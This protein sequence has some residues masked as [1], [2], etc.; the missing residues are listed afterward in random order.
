MK[1]EKEK[2]KIILHTCCAVCGAFLAEKLKENFEPAIFFYNPNIWPKEEYNKR[3]ESAQEL[4]RIYNLK[5][6]EGDHEHE[7]WLGAVKGFEKEPEDGKRCEICFKMR[8]SKAAELAKTE[9]IE[10][11]ATTLSISPY[12]N[13]KIVNEIG[14]SIRNSSGIKFLKL[15]DICDKKE[16]WQKTRQLSKEYNFYHQNYCGCE[17]SKK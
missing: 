17:F 2:S 14:E 5:F 13:E 1:S 11:F 8:L 7:K 15:E 6:I 3:K 10:Y 9:R 4:A 12:K 16:A